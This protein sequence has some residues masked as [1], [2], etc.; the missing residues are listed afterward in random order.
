MGGLAAFYGAQEVLFSPSAVA[1]SVIEACA[2]AAWVLGTN[3]EATE[4]RLARAY[5]EELKSAEEAKKNAGRLLGKEHPEYL[6]V[7]EDSSGAVPKSTKSSPADGRPTRTVGG[8][9]TGR[10]C[11]MLGMAYI[12]I[13]AEARRR[14]FCVPHSGRFAVCTA[15]PQESILCMAWRGIPCGRLACNRMVGNIR[16]RVPSGQLVAGSRLDQGRRPV[17]LRPHSYRFGPTLTI[18]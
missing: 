1:R 13:R 6:R 3:G 2:S 16:H 7:A 17:T 4:N 8:S 10:A 15:G 12:A 9:C 5:R 11:R 18:E 14:K